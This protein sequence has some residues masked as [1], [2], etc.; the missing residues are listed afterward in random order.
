MSLFL[1]EVW[2][3]DPN[4]EKMKEAIEIFTALTTAP[5]SITGSSSADIKVIAG[6]W[7]SNEEAKV[8]LVLDIADH[9]PLVHPFA[10]YMAR[11]LFERR[12][13]TPIVNWS[14]A[15]TLATSL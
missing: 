15:Q 10:R 14:E 6:P 1:D 9:T 2:I 7:L 5:E 4:P 3:K 11:G 12:R 8:I 13:F